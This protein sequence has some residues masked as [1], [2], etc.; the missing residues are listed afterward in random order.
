M[1]NVERAREF[2]IRARG[3]IREGNNRVAIVLLARAFHALKHA[4][5]LDP[6]NPDAL[7][8]WAVENLHTEAERHCAR[9]IL[10]V[11]NQDDFDELAASTRSEPLRRGTTLTGPRS[12][13]GPST[14]GGRERPGR[15]RRRPS[16]RPPLPALRSRDIVET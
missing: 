1:A 14:P 10:G 6:W 11:W 12:R 4:A 3:Q 8:H 7:Y 2:A 16:L 15:A 5:G 9:F 13:S